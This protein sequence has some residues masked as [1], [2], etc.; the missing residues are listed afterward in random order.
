[1]QSVISE[2]LGRLRTPFV[3]I[4]QASYY[5]PT[6]FERYEVGRHDESGR[7]VLCGI[8]KTVTGRDPY[9]NSRL[10]SEFSVITSQEKALEFVRKNGFLLNEHNQI[11]FSDAMAIEDLDFFMS[12]AHQAN[13]L[14]N[15]LNLILRNDVKKIK[16]LLVFKL[17][18]P[19]GKNAPTKMQTLQS[20]LCGECSY[21]IVFAGEEWTPPCD[22]INVFDA[23]DSKKYL[24]FAY[25]FLV[26]R[27]IEKLSQVKLEFFNLIPS[28][29]CRV[30]YKPIPAYSLENMIDVMYFSF[31]AMLCNGIEV[32]TC[33]YCGNEF[34]PERK[35]VRYCPECLANHGDNIYELTRRKAKK[36][37]NQ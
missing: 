20:A 5:Q 11:I 27:I 31:Y 16:G 14:R 7:L 13:L 37:V 25:F 8:G 10:F 17:K 26:L 19:L 3:E 4:K 22:T 28:S 1:M 18:R 36:G 9:K 29:G 2:S 33:K 32:Y 24:D 34:A 21:Q 15:L 23:F 30:K 6:I 12:E 35:N